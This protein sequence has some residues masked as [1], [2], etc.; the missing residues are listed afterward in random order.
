MTHLE[1]FQA[2]CHFEQP[3]YVPIFGFHGAPGMAHGC[4]RPTHER[5]VAQGMPDWVDGSLALG[6]AWSTET[7]QRYWGTTGAIFLDFFPADPGGPGIKSEMRIE[8]EWEIIECETG[9][10]TRQVINNAAEYSMPEFIRYDVTDRKSWEFYRER[11]APGPRWSAE[12][13]EEACRKFDGRDKPLCIGVGSTFGALRGVMGP[14]LAS[15]VLYDDPALAH[16]IIDQGTR[17]LETYLFP[18]IER[19]R[20]EVLATGEDCCFNHGML[21]SPK[22]FREF[23]APHYREIGEIARA[24]GVDMVA[25]DADGNAMELVPIVEES[26]VNA[27]CPFEVKAGNDL[28]A[29]RERHPKFILMGWLEKEVVNEGNGHLIEPEIMSKVPPLLAKGG[30]FP[31]GDHG[32]QPWVTFENL[33][34]FMTLLHEVC[35]NPEGEFPRI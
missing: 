7:W 32:I 5:L 1:R 3:D 16:E 4:L 34:R 23:C 6:E 19:L 31:N 14:Y 22:H 28:F 18:V 12:P 29:L 2:I 11:T 10:L 30:Y 15:T 24:C 9:A 21:L 17:A 27:I 20:P 8:G 33:C 26:G 25:I 13:I 35:G